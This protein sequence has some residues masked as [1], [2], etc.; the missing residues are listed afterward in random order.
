M[1]RLK[2]SLAMLLSVAMMFSNL[3]IPTT[4]YAAEDEM[5]EVGGSEDIVVDD[6]QSDIVNEEAEKAPADTGEENLD[7]LE[8]AAPAQVEEMTE[9]QEEQV[10]NAEEDADID[11]DVEEPVE[12]KAKEEQNDSINIGGAAS[13]T[14]FE[15][16]LAKISGTATY[17]ADVE[18]SD[19]VDKRTDEEDIT[20]AIS[21]EVDGKSYFG[22]RSYPDAK[23]VYSAG[24]NI[25][26][27]E[28]NR[29]I[30]AQQADEEQGLD[31]TR[32]YLNVSDNT[33]ITVYAK[34]QKTGTLKLVHKGTAGDETC[35]FVEITKAG[36]LYELEAKDAGLHYIYS[37]D[38]AWDF[39]YITASVSAAARYN[40]T[41][42]ENEFVTITRVNVN[43][44]PSYVSGYGDIGDWI[45]AVREGDKVAISMAPADGYIISDVIVKTDSSTEH[46]LTENG[47]T[48]SFIMPAENATVV[49]KC[50]EQVIT[51]YY[52]LTVPEGWGVY[53]YLKNEKLSTSTNDDDSDYDFYSISENSLAKVIP[54][55]FKSSKD[56]C[57]S[58]YDSSGTPVSVEF[59]DESKGTSDPWEFDGIDDR[60]IVENGDYIIV[61]IS[62]DI[63]VDYTN[64]NKK[65]NVSGE[66][67]KYKIG[68]IDEAYAPDKAKVQAGEYVHII[69]VNTGNVVTRIY[70]TYPAAGDTRFTASKNGDDW[71]FKM[72]SDDVNVTLETRYP[73]TFD[74]S[75][76]L[77]VKSVSVQV[78]GD[79][80]AS[81]LGTVNVKSGQN[82]TILVTM[83]KDVDYRVVDVKVNGTSATRVVG[84]RNK[85]TFE[86]TAE[87][88]VI[89]V[90]TETTVPVLFDLRDDG[91]KSVTVAT[92]KYGIA[93][94]TLSEDAVNVV[95]GVY[96]ATDSVVE[97]TAE[98][99][100]TSFRNVR[101]YDHEVGKAG[102]VV[103]QGSTA[104]DFTDDKYT[105]LNLNDLI[106]VTTTP[107]LT[108]FTD[109]ITATDDIVSIKY[110]ISDNATEYTL[111]QLPASSTI[112]E[113]NAVRAAYSPT[114]SNEVKTGDKLAS[115]TI[116][117]RAGVLIESI[118]MGEWAP[119]EGE[120]P[121]AGAN[122][123]AKIFPKPGVVEDAGQYTYTFDL[124]SGVAINEAKVI[125]INY[126]PSYKVS[127]VTGDGITEAVPYMVTGDVDYSADIK[128]KYFKAGEVI[129]VKPSVITGRENY[130]SLGNVSVNQVNNDVQMVCE[131]TPHVR[132][133]FTMPARDVTLYV[134]SYTK[135]TVDP[136]NVGTFKLMYG[137]HIVEDGTITVEGPNYVPETSVVRIHSNDVWPTV[138]NADDLT[139]VAVSP[140]DITEDSD[141]Y[142]FAM[143]DKNVKV[144]TAPQKVERIDDATHKAFVTVSGNVTQG[145][146]I[147]DAGVNFTEGARISFSVTPN[148]NN[149][150]KSVTVKK[151][152]DDS[153]YE[154]QIVSGSEGSF[155]M[156]GYD[157]YIEA[158]TS[159]TFSL[160]FQGD[161]AFKENTNSETIVD[162]TALINAIDVRIGAGSA[163]PES[164]TLAALTGSDV[165][166]GTG[167]RLTA[168]ND[169]HTI[170]ISANAGYR[171]EDVT[172]ATETS[173][174]SGI[175]T[176]DMP[177]VDTEVTVRVVPIHVITVS[178]NTT[179]ATVDYAIGTAVTGDIGSNTIPA[180]GKEQAQGD[181]IH[182]RPHATGSKLVTGIKL[183]DSAGNDISGTANLTV[184]SP[185]EFTPN[186][187]WVDAQWSF[188]MTDGSV[189]IVPSTTDIYTLGREN[190][191]TALADFEYTITVGTT[192]AVVAKAN[193]A[194]TSALEV[195]A[196]SKISV[197][198]DSLDAQD[199]Y[200]QPTMDVSGSD[201]P[202]ILGEKAVIF[203]Q[204]HPEYGFTMPAA[205][206]TLYTK[207]Y[208]VDVADATGSLAA[209]GNDYVVTIKNTDLAMYDA[210]A[211]LNGSKFAIG[212]P[213]SFEVKAKDTLTGNAKSVKRGGTGFEQEIAPVEGVYSFVVSDTASD[214][215]SNKFTVD[216]V[217]TRE[218]SFSFLTTPEGC[219]IIDAAEA[220]KTLSVN[221]IT[222]SENQTS[223]MVN[224]ATEITIAPKDGYKIIS[225]ANSGSGTLDLTPESGTPYYTGK[226]TVGES[227]E[228][229]TI[230]VVPVY[231]VTVNDTFADAAWTG[232]F[233]AQYVAGPY[234]SGFDTG[235]FTEG[236]AVVLP[237]DTIVNISNVVFGTT[238]DTNTE[239]SPLYR[240][241][242]V[243]VKTGTN[244]EADA[245]YIANEYTYKVGDDIGTTTPEVGSAIDIDVNVL[246][247]TKVQ[248]VDDNRGAYD[249]TY[250]DSDATVDRSAITDGT[251]TMGTVFRISKDGKITLTPKNQSSIKSV[252]VALANDYKTEK[253]TDG[254][255]VISGIEC[256]ND[257][258]DAKVVIINATTD[259][260][261]MLGFEDS[262]KDAYNTEFTAAY[263]GEA[264]D[265]YYAPEVAGDTHFSAG[266]EITIVPMTGY[267]IENVTVVNGSSTPGVAAAVTG[268]SADGKYVVKI[269]KENAQIKVATVPLHKL[270]LAVDPTGTAKDYVQLE[271]SAPKYGLKVSEN[272]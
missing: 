113:V 200:A 147:G 15:D 264:V 244:A 162:Q 207:A 197:T 29:Y 231:S 190:S 117:G 90:E 51:K 136:D 19:V 217:P 24:T 168:A 156:P 262:C 130:Y 45:G 104:I 141:T 224:E 115:F 266:D 233:Q 32:V 42:S 230:E 129:T 142:C 66:G 18:L 228:T 78:D 239:A 143:P 116:T 208:T 10:S 183:L 14:A 220:L 187:G 161:A 98:S 55:G 52:D 252:A 223:Y 152:S 44:L 242:N 28:K 27:K 6:Q 87:P 164:V 261:Y 255:W 114:A 258:A 82:A 171:I 185:A 121:A 46:T 100:S 57:L 43:D 13:D 125:K 178:E 169:T 206:A 140:E 12:E 194:T 39:N 49:I 70:Y 253:Q 71:Y 241:K 1:L 216:F 123:G 196:G 250:T 203:A 138:L 89:T 58:V 38:T 176:F 40:L 83:Q 127:L 225:I 53:D 237:K 79:A 218:I 17:D 222:I 26:G 30:E 102:L 106:T 184:T 267:R 234:A 76:A 240:V 77:G 92:S 256:D 122:Y 107:Y 177:A 165:L 195:P 96:T 204:D 159:P 69:P 109:G 72:P 65:Y 265:D 191:V 146:V 21:K 148:E 88:M 95:H 269:G 25:G 219:G 64:I 271:A 137:A 209:L 37:D 247:R 111:S 68:T 229:V 193:A 31:G 182:I 3:Y 245:T 97:F 62:D 172:G 210:G 157:V 268:P 180:N 54:S 61:Q 93:D 158:V 60:S 173:L 254:S 73:I 199:K 188:V 103:K 105:A 22:L 270:T 263:N 232:G 128:D 186:T 8:D 205:N 181:V 259:A 257:I 236:A 166:V 160:A 33:L 91:V 151:K 94:M 20:N 9:Q 212:T 101:Y 84:D 134:P 47:K 124:G 16:V 155:I 132:W 120:T 149:E 201:D 192:P 198:Y 36:G 85:Y 144:F 110:T 11:E 131:T 135:Y 99:N 67:F 167:N 251:A 260:Y 2:R 59:H 170:T 243:T 139:D 211:N 41:I 7:S 48:W 34:G 226:L 213:V 126:V 154:Q 119:G 174:G 133:S 81:T 23:A 163:T 118:Q 175:W 189:V 235:A 221:G 179:I 214:T 248:V 5:I 112:D 150:L 238:S 215:E 74:N 249:I 86:T 63:A 50:E 202:F 80:S 56:M 145:V 153:V 227:A 75:G 35:D 108:L 246:H 272:G 4:V